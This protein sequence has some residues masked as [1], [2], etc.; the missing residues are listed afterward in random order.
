MLHQCATDP[1]RPGGRGARQGRGH[2]SAADRRLCF[3]SLA[4]ELV[5]G[6]SPPELHLCPSAV[7]VGRCVWV[8]LARTRRGAGEAAKGDAARC[9]QRSASACACASIGRSLSRATSPTRSSACA[10][11]RCAGST[12]STSVASGEGGRALQMQ[13]VPGADVGLRWIH[14]TRARAHGSALVH[15]RA[16]ARC[17]M[18]CLHA[19]ACSPG[20]LTHVCL[21]RPPA[22]PFPSRSPSMC[23][24]TAH[25]LCA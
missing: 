21:R 14:A 5:H 7:C 4:Q 13:A 18:R 3:L 24:F 12:G 2:C 11:R 19:I 20:A 17:C 6:T 16:D 25:W 23:V 1:I 10:A 22:R 8:G 15:T 9:D